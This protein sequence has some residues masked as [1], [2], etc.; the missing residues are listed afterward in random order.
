MKTS[1][2]KKFLIVIVAI[3]ILSVFVMPN[4]SHAGWLSDIG[5]NLLNAVFDLIRF[6]GDVI[7]GIMQKLMTGYS[8]DVSKGIYYSPGII[9]SNKVQGLKVNFIT[10]T[11]KDITQ[12][13][14]QDDTYKMEDVQKKLEQNYETINSEYFGTIFF[15]LDDGNVLGGDRKSL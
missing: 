2:L 8:M 3:A 5:N 14:V 9:F 11:N 6:I 1:I 7:L 15:R 10:A 13:N 4:K 12:P